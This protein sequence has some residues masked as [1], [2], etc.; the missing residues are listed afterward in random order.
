M[1][2]R[3]RDL[4]RAV[5]TCKTQA[6]ERAVVQ[7]ESALVRQ[8]LHAGINRGPNMLKLMYISMLGYSTEFGQLEVVKL[9]AESDFASKR[10]GYLALNV[11]LDESQE[12]L[13]LAEN[14]I[15]RDLVS[16]SNPF[17][18]GL[19]LDAVANI[20]GDDMSRDMMNEVYTLLGS[21][22]THTRKKAALAAQRAVRKAPEL[23][24]VF[25]E[26]ERML[27]F[28]NERNHG[29]LVSTLAL[30]NEC[31]SS[32]NGQPYLK[33][34]SPLIPAAVRQLS[35]L[36]MSGYAM[37]HEV[38]GIA[39]PFL[40]VKLLHF[41]RIVGRGS[42]EAAEA[43]NNVL[44]QTATNTPIERNVGCS[45]LY[46]CVRTILAIECDES[47]RLLA[48]NILG[49]FMDR[50]N[51]C[52]FVALSM[53]LDVVRVDRAVAQRHRTTVIDCLKD[54]D[55]SI[56][57][58][59]LQL[60]VALVDDTN[61]RLM[62][63]DLLAYLGVCSEE[64]RDDTTRQ[65]C[66]V[67]EQQSPTHEWRIEM[68]VKLFRSANARTTESFAT[69]FI[70]AVTRAET[71]IQ[72]RAAKAIWEEFKSVANDATSQ[73]A[74][75][76]LL[77]AGCWLSGEYAQLLCPSIVPQDVVVSTLSAMATDGPT[78]LVQ[79]FAL[80]ALVKI[81]SKFADTVAV[82]LS[83]F[84]LCA[85]SMDCEIQ[86]RAAEYAVMLRTFAG[87]LAEF[88]FSPGG[89][90]ADVATTDALAI[91]STPIE[92]S[93]A[94]GGS[95]VAPAPAPKPVKK[96][97]F[98][99]L[100]TDEPPKP[101][102]TP[103]T[104]S[105]SSTN[106]ASPAAASQQQQQRA[107][108]PSLIDDIFGGS[109]AATPRRAPSRRLRRCRLRWFRWRRP[110]R[111][112]QLR[113]RKPG[114]A[115][116]MPP[117]SRWTSTRLHP[118]SAVDVVYYITAKSAPVSK[119]VLLVAVPK[120]CSLDLQAPPTDAVPSGGVLEHKMTVKHLA[121]QP[122]PKL[123]MKVKLTYSVHGEGRTIDFQFARDLPLAQ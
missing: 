28:L 116:T 10:V 105:P 118:S 66:G 30:V 106:K 93:G 110:P 90:I 86:Q 54:V 84:D 112:R 6:E 33:K 49:R 14:H 111:R 117:T 71:E 37:E 76:G 74:R 64:M 8:Q 99:D 98:D 77:L 13:T 119:V 73:T 102:G 70:T 78:P 25:L 16:P 53:F 2:S 120:S 82:A 15:K 58:R 63:S 72:Q 21:T 89:P 29:V 47:L 107:A 40:Q 7:R 1:S 59:A 61:V 100:F 19:A 36:V 80:T 17:I 94:T 56:R 62:S 114:S 34:F 109:A 69:H 65:L 51:N 38:S 23:V 103:A 3:L 60:T 52:R 31:L 20:A 48:Y 24:D 75:Q 27:H 83:V 11:L 67:I 97:L 85:T 46:E 121:G 87:D 32:P 79:Q 108:Q 101:A 42:E 123:S 57:R 88:C 104:G 12:V 91:P 113:R 122:I 115:C 41:L 22:N 5:R 39:D 26:D 81:G 9:L 92:A 68:S 55:L 45:V 44:A 50:D 18:Q 43:M 95:A 35:S 96:D 4:I